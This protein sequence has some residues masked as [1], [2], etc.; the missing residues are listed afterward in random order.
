MKKYAVLSMD[1]E[2]WYHLDYIKTTT[3]SDRKYS[4]LDGFDN[5][6][7]ILIEQNLPASFFILSSLVNEFKHR[8]NKAVIKSSDFN[9]HG[10]SHV[11]PLSLN[12]KDF[13]NEIIQ[14]K[15]NIED[16][17]SKPVNGF[18]A[19][20]FNLN[21]EYLKILL[22]NNYLFDSSKIEFKGHPLYGNIEIPNFKEI[23]N[24]IYSYNNFFEFEIP[25]QNFMNRNIPISGGG[26]LRIFPLF[27]L[28]YLLKKFISNNNFFCFYLHPFELSKKNNPD[29]LKY[30]SFKINRRFKTGRTTSIKKLINIIKFLKQNE[31]EFINFSN[32]QSVLIKNE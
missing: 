29:Y 24:N 1:I 5:F 4:M 11:K 25:T 7:N 19:P 23:Y 22:N 30:Q 2:D 27:F 14:S 20:C 18:R 26:Y 12:V 10:I 28:K 31:F 8:L 9:S 3:D 15:K 13:K 16:S 17:L 21:D 32:L 6:Q